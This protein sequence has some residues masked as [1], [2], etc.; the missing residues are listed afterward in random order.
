[1]PHLSLFLGYELACTDTR[2]HCVDPL[3][4]FPKGSAPAQDQAPRRN[5]KNVQ[6]RTS[7]GSCLPW[8][9]IHHCVCLGLLSS[10][11]FEFRT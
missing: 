1:M 9:F 4:Q 2:C 5:K 3:T 7:P 6:I 8:A 11:R 10:M